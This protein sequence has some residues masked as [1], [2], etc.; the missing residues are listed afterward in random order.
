M[1]RVS[2][3]CDYHGLGEVIEEIGSMEIVNGLNHPE[4]PVYGNYNIRFFD[5]DDQLFKETKVCDHIRA[6]GI[7]ELLYRA[8]DEAFGPEDQ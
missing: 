6:N 7:W 8:L 2:I 5:K 1:I 3:D 4:R